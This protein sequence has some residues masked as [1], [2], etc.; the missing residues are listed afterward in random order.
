MSSSQPRLT[1]I[2]ENGGILNFRLSEIDVS[3]ANSLRR[4]IL[5]EIPVNIIRT[6]SHLSNLC[7][8]LINTTRFHNEILKNRLSCIPIHTRDLNLLP[9]N[10]QL[11][12]DQKNTTENIIYIT[13]ENFQLKNKKTG[14]YMPEEE[15]HRIFPSNPKTLSYIDFVRLRP[16]ISDSIPGEHLKLTADFSI[17]NAKENAMYNVVSKCAYG[18]TPDIAKIEKVWE[19]REAKLRGEEMPEK[20]IAFQKRNFMLLDAQRIFVP[21]SFDF[22]IKSIEIYENR[23]IVKMAAKILYEKFAKFVEEL[24]SNMVP[25]INSETT[26]ENCFDILLENE[27][28][29][30]GKVFEYLLY[31]KYYEGEKTLEFCGFK[32][33]HPHDLKSTVRIAFKESVG[34]DKTIAK[35]YIRTAA[36]D[37]QDIF[38]VIYKMF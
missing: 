35:Q 30:M 7:N 25:I 13:T 22:Q 14:E 33:F 17:G 24:D 6:E 23:E 10:Y 12:I 31:E 16:K 28:Y 15:V 1:E 29:T 19:E 34:S 26:I 9:D 36:M 27:D 3:I 4:T 21:N 38:K 11:E 37:A 20:D 18:N 2:F 8:I 32:K 5:T